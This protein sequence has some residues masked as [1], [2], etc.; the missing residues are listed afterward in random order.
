MEDIGR[1]ENTTR[2][3]CIDLDGTL[4]HS[5]L[6]IESALSLLKK[7]PFFIFAMLLWLTKERANLKRQIAIRITLQCIIIALQP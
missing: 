1:M 5:D 3:L 7:N 2:P 4:I 6:L